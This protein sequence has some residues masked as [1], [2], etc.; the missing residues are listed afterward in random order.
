MGTILA[1]PF[2]SNQF[3]AILVAESYFHIILEK[4]GSEETTLF[5][6]IV[7][8]LRNPTQGGSVI[9]VSHNVPQKRLSRGHTSIRL[10]CI[11]CA[12]CLLDWL[13]PPFSVVKVKLPLF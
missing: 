3:Y 5:N 8:Q 1:Q 2:R 10:G 13:P 4:E 12:D 9:C 6:L 7:L 11:T